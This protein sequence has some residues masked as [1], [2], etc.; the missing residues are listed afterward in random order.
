MVEYRTV[1]GECKSLA[2]PLARPCA[3]SLSLPPSCPSGFPPLCA[4]FPP[5][6]AAPAGSGSFDRPRSLHDTR[7]ESGGAWPRV[8]CGSRWPTRT[9]YWATTHCKTYTTVNVGREAPGV[10]SRYCASRQRDATSARVTARSHPAR[11][12]M[13]VASQAIV[14]LRS[15]D[16]KRRSEI[17]GAA[18]HD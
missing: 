17:H 16:D 13:Y 15:Q 5:S 9:Q 1:W 7:R 14:D 10:P 3:L 11:P 6:S 12:R 18:V 4:S 8:L 2:S